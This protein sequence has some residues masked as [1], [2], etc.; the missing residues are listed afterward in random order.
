[1]NLKSNVELKRKRIKL[2]TYDHCFTGCEAVDVAY[3][4]LVQHRENMINKELS[5]EKAI[6]VHQKYIFVLCLGLTN[7]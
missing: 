5:R 2:K 1:M 7:S 6:K 3:Q 4:F